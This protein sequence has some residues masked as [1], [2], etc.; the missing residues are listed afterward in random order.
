MVILTAKVSRGKLAAIVLLLLATVVLLAVLLG[1]ADVP[2]EPS[3]SA[4]PSPGSVR[5]GDDRIA[6]LA[7][8]GW[9]VA[10][11]PIQTQEVRIPTDP[12]DLFER[13][14]D[15][16]RTQG[17][18][19]HDY[20]GKTVRRYVYEVL[21]HPGSGQ[22]YATLL[23]YKNT[24]IGGDVCSA[25]KGG[26]MHGFAMPQAEAAALDADSAETGALDAEATE[27]AALDAESTE[28]AALIDIPAA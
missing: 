16:Q 17:F 26:S 14:N 9:E 8:F 10:P 23:V 22:Y 28:P 6:Y 20:A 21:N 19:L 3:E 4:Q 7:A 5:T 24:V 18:D 12:S 25:E 27:P 13:Y 2:N 11:E 1:R 15:L